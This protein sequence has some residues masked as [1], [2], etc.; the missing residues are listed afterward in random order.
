[1]FTLVLGLHW[2]MAQQSKVYFFDLKEYNEALTLYNN[3]QYQAAQTLFNRVKSKTTDNETLANSDYYIANSA[4]RLNQ[5]GADKLMEAFVKEHPTST[6]RNSAFMDVADYYYQSGKYS[7]A[8]KWYTKTEPKN[9]S[10]KEEERYNFN[11]GYCLFVAKKYG[12]AKKY[13]NKLLTSKETGSQAK[14]N[15]LGP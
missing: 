1:M 2:G 6:K 15:V 4:I 7:L 11:I 5:R 10:N 12:P 14:K 8:L 3:K 9:L 13:F